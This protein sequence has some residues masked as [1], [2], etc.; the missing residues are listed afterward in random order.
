[1]EPLTFEEQRKFLKILL[2]QYETSANIVANQLQQIAGSNAVT[3]RWGVL[4]QLRIIDDIARTALKSQD[5]LDYYLKRRDVFYGIAIKDVKFL[6][7]E[8]HGKE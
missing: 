3:L 2:T 8:S 4:N 7:G 1:M 6:E 5:L